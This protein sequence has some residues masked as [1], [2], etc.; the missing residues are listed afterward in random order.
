MYLAYK[1]MEAYEQA[2]KITYDFVIRIRPD[3]ILK[4]TI[5]FNEIYQ[6]CNQEYIEK[7]LYTIKNI[8]QFNTIFSQETLIVL[9]NIFYN[10]KRIHYN[11]FSFNN[12]YNNK[13]NDLIEKYTDNE[14]NFIEEIHKYITN[15]NYVIALRENVV[16]FTNREC[17]KKIHTLGLT[18]G[19]HILK[20]HDYWFNAESQL[21]QICIENDIDFYSSISKL[22]EKSLYQYENHN[23]FIG[24]KQELDE[25]GEF[26]FFIKRN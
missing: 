6:K 2:N 14:K 12:I 3:T 22:E 26:S 25:Q 4:D 19:Q 23:Y 10:E 20:N 16:Y 8:K 21:K 5:N 24:E 18:Y 17:M 1:E 9:M 11:D 15:G 13:F 7:L